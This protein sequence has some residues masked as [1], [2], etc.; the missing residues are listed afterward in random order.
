MATLRLLPGV[1]VCVMAE[2]SLLS[3]THYLAQVRCI[4]SSRT[5]RGAR[6]AGYPSDW[7][8]PVHW[9]TRPGKSKNTFTYIL[10]HPVLLHIT[11]LAIKGTQRHLVY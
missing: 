4:V 1:S 5:G 7:S 6:Y 11:R 9:T 8:E 2:R 3:S 10:T